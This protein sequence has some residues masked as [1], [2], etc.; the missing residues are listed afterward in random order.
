MRAA[1]SGA[2]FA[3]RDTTVRSGIKS[4]QRGAGASS[5]SDQQA[6]EDPATKLEALLHRGAGAIASRIG[7]AP[8]SQMFFRPEE[9]EHRSEPRGGA[10]LALAATPD[11]HH[12]SFGLWSWV[13]GVNGERE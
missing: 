8:I 13:V 10:S 5:V 2:A 6:T 9:V 1:A 11:P 12:D 7:P 3:A 4:P